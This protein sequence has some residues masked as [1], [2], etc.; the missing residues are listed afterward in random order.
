MP[1]VFFT[2]RGQQLAWLPSINVKPLKAT[3]NAMGGRKMIVNKDV[4]IICDI[5]QY[6]VRWTAQSA[7][8]FTPWLSGL[9]RHQLAE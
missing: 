6:P 4:R 8:H 9:S 3:S 1:W 5:A 7:L 2:V